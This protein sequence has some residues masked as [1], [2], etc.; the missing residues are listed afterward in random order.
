MAVP[1][2]TLA[3]V[4]QRSAQDMRRPPTP[5][6][7]DAPKSRF[8]TPP[9]TTTLLTPDGTPPGMLAVPAAG[10]SHHASSH[11]DSSMIAREHV[12]SPALFPSD[13]RGARSPLAS[14]EMDWDKHVSCGPFGGDEGMEGLISGGDGSAP[15]V[16]SAGDVVVRKKPKRCSTPADAATAE[17]RPPA[18][19]TSQPS[20]ADTQ[21]WNDVPDDMLANNRVYKQ[22]QKRNMDRLDALRSGDAIEAVVIL[23]DDP[24]NRQLRHVAKRH[25]LRT[26]SEC[27]DST[28]SLG[29]A[30]HRAN[31]D[32]A[33]VSRRDRDTGD[34]PVLDRGHRRE[35][36][37]RHKK[38]FEPSCRSVSAPLASNENSTYASPYSPTVRSLRHERRPLSSGGRPQQTLFSPT[39]FGGVMSSPLAPSELALAHRGNEQPRHSSL[40]GW[41]L[42]RPDHSNLLTQDSTNHELKRSSHDHRLEDLPHRK[43]GRPSDHEATHQASPT[44]SNPA[45]VGLRKSHRFANTY[46]PLSIMSDRTELEVCEAKNVALFPHS[47]GSVFLVDTGSLS[48]HRAQSKSSQP[49]AIGHQLLSMGSEDEG[50]R[51]RSSS[52]SVVRV[53]ATPEIKLDGGIPAIDDTFTSLRVAPPPPAIQFIPPTPS[54][55]DDRQVE[56]PEAR[57]APTSPDVQR[58][59]SLLRRARRLSD[60]IINPLLSRSNSIRKRQVRRPQH[61][62]DA[63]NDRLH[64]M[65]QPT[66]MWDD[67]D[68]YVDD[69]DDDYDDY[70]RDR[71][72]PND[73]EPLPRGGDTSDH[74]TSNPQRTL[75]FPRQ[76]SVR[77]PGFRGDGGF[78]LGNSLG[79]DRHG[80]NRRR[81]H[82][83]LPAKGGL[84]RRRRVRFFGFRAIRARIR[85]T[86]AH[87]RGGPDTEK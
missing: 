22:I 3:L 82:V 87:Y 83:E 64:P 39:P 66:R 1:A 71:D 48:T 18:R 43:H 60:S 7:D 21:T 55:D 69:C 65:W 85:G 12:R 2:A 46:T 32:Y 10:L 38:A 54:N 84:A 31:G 67:D 9:N 5:P 36:S 86:G 17:S 59:D 49:D 45:F 41:D 37:L 19:S 34:S 68:D 29:S 16:A 62:R 24:R 27:E 52:E 44:F 25:S 14:F 4:E 11:A 15:D 6:I 70:D 81:P 63:S 23:T 33:S 72:H 20:P 73:L 80:S 56:S 51:S 42:N 53:T 58:R 30:H 28:P 13:G 61:V 77:M 75:F 74:P 57:C 47:N 79:V 35:L 8:A 78:L 40:P 50:S 26:E 76:M